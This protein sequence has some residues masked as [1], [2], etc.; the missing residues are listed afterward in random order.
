MTW[1]TVGVF[2]PN[3][4][5]QRLAMSA[6][7]SRSVWDSVARG[8]ASDGVVAR[9]HVPRIVD[10]VV[11]RQRVTSAWRRIAGQITWWRAGCRQPAVRRGA[12][13]GL[14]ADGRH[15]VTRK[16]IIRHAAARHF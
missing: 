4:I 8:E 6:V 14:R 15:F 5:E 7:P 16:G 11:A 12:K 1:N 3:E 2:S 9:H 10:P 13:A